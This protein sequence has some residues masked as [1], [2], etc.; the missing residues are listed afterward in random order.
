[1]KNFFIGLFIVCIGIAIGN[2]LLTQT[3]ALEVSVLRDITDSSLSELTT[4][5]LQK[6]F[7]FENRKWEGSIFRFANITD[8]GLN[9]VSEIGI[10]PA[11]ELLSNELDRD[12][13]ISVFE[14]SINSIL[15]TANN[16]SIG[17]LHSSVYRPIAMELLHLNL[18]KSQSK[19]LLIYSDLMENEDGLSLYSKSM[20]Q[21]IEQNPELLKTTFQKEEPLPNLSGITIYIIFQ[22]K[23]TEQDFQFKVMSQLYRSLLEEKGATVFIKANL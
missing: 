14:K 7:S 1:M 9:H 22:P 20:L 23:N 2:L 8:V 21:T 6:L 19:V 15:L 11:Y 18:S 5:D 10:V 16:D 12:K 3:L 4:N 13:Q 17:R